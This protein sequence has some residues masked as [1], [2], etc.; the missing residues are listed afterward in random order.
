MAISLTSVGVVYTGTQSPSQ[1]S[2]SGAAYTLDDYEEGSWTPTIYY[3]NGT[4]NGNISYSHQNGRY[5][6]VGYMVTIWESILWTGGGTAA[7]NIGIGSLPFTP[8][9]SATYGTA[10]IALVITGSA[11]GNTVSY[12]ARLADTIA[13]TIAPC[14][15]GGNQGATIGTGNKTLS[16]STTYKTP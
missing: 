12:Y 5:G 2:G 13:A 11:A 16:G 1:S 7:D 14:I 9:S 15:G 10:T 8:Q 4:D 6:K 3:Q